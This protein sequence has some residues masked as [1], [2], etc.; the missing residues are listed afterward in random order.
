MIEHRDKR[1]FLRDGNEPSFDRARVAVLPVPYEATV[2]YGRGTA[3]GPEAILEA[4]T[5]IE[6]Y[7]ERMAWV[8]SECGIWTDDPLAVEARI[9]QAV[10]D[11]RIELRQEFHEQPRVAQPLQRLVRMMPTESLRQLLEDELGLEA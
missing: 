9:R 7:N 2:S 5:Q 8:P 11:G 3:R 10:R 6:S 1:I 4:S